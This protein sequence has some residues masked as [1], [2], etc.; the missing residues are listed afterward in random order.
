MNTSFNSL[1]AVTQ[2]LLSNNSFTITIQGLLTFIIIEPPNIPEGIDF[3]GVYIPYNHEQ[4]QRKTTK[5]TVTCIKNGKEFKK[6]K[7][8]K[9]INVKVED[10]HV[11]LKEN[12]IKIKII[13]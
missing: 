3:G 13:P 2:G 5:I 12:K 8:I 6:T 1:D 4:P 11:E 9:K 7:Y 10:I